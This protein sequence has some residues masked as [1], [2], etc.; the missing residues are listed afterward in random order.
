[1]CR[2]LLYVGKKSK[3]LY[4]VLMES[5]NSLWEQSIN[6]RRKNLNK[7]DH[8]INIDGF[9]MGWLKEEF[10]VYKNPVPP[11][12]DKNI[13]NLSRSIESKVIMGHIRAVKNPRKCLI[14]YENCHPFNSDGFLMMHNGLICGFEFKKHE[15]IRK[16]KDKYISRISGQTDSEVIFY[17]FLS[18]LESRHPKDIVKAFYKMLETLKSIYQNVISA[19]IVISNHDYS[20]I[21]RFINNSEEPPSLYYLIDENEVRVSSEP[22]DDKE[23]KLLGKNK[24]IFINHQNLKIS[25]SDY[26]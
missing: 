9:G 22:E 1:M 10:I 23:W 21:S 24:I 3:S 6:P 15:V 25:I 20:I 18:L 26:L 8:L 4:N 7:R 5:K 12:H 11:F 19:N 16:I 13:I 17:L 14:S 2:L